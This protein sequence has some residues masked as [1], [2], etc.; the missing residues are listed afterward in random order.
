M[1]HRLEVLEHL[2]DLLHGALRVGQRDLTPYT[3]QL[4]KP[5]GRSL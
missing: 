5:G 1:A 4:H 3:E 2:D